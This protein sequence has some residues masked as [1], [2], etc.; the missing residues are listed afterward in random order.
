MAEPVRIDG[1][2]LVVLAG[3]RAGRRIVRGKRPDEIFRTAEHGHRLDRANADAPGPGAERGKRLRFLD[4]FNNHW[5]PRFDGGFTCRSVSTLH[6]REALS[7]RTIETVRDKVETAAGIVPYPQT[8][9]I[10][11]VSLDD[12]VEKPFGSDTN[13]VRNSEM[14][15]GPCPDALQRVQLP[16]RFRQQSLELRALAT[17]T[18]PPSMRSRR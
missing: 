12:F 11:P 13:R 15:T 1:V 5:S 10:G 16:A 4:V 7:R 14:R 18:S 9:E 3:K 2:H 8:P 17:V 6:N